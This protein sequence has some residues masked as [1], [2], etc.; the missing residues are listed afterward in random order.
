GAPNVR[1]G[2]YVACALPGAVLPGDLKIKK[3]KL[4]GEKSC[5]M[6]CSGS[7]LRL[8]ADASGI[9]DLGEGHLPGTP[10]EKSLGISDTV[11]EI[12]LTPNRPD[13]LSVIGVAREI[14]A[15]TEPMG[16][17]KLPEVVLPQEKMVSKSI[18]DYAKV[19][20]VDGDLCPRYSAGMLF[21]VKVGPSPFWLRQKLESVGL[22]PINNV[23]DVTNFVM[24]ETGQPLH[25]FDFDNL[26]KGRIIV[27][28]AGSD[29]D[30]TTLDS[31]EHKLESEMLMICDGERSVALAGV[32]G[33]ENSEISDTTTCVLIESAYFNPISIRR[34]AKKTG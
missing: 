19:E 24:L 4:R 11:F 29:I 26:A 5:G 10:L 20:I 21:D 17:V 2:M 33:G 25:A 32:M 13:C 6:L 27:K 7:E 28:K 15:F 1:Q 18:H 16:Q 22:T 23:V 31:K 34:T 12:D 3:S 14:G 30:F 8:A 9:M